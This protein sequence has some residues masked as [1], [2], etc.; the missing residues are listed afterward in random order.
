MRPEELQ[1]FSVL[2]LCTFGSL[3]LRLMR[4]GSLQSGTSTQIVK[5]YFALLSSQFVNCIF[6][7]PT[8]IQKE[9]PT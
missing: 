4:A 5:I 9:E 3:H 1:I 6:C 2:S 8:E 7:F